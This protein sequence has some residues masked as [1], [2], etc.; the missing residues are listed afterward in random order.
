MSARD[1]ADFAEFG[2]DD[3]SRVDASEPNLTA[4]ERAAL[5][6]LT[7]RGPALRIE[8]ERIPWPRVET[9]LFT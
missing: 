5:E 2:V 4:G 7:D 9:T 6:L 8:Q 1:V 3:P